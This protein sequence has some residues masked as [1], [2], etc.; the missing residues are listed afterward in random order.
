MDLEKLEETLCNLGINNFIVDY[1]EN[2]FSLDALFGLLKREHNTLGLCPYGVA[3][4]SILPYKITIELYKGDI[5]DKDTLCYIPSDLAEKLRQKY[6]EKVFNKL[7]HLMSN[8]QYEGVIEF[9]NKLISDRKKTIMA[10]K[11]LDVD[12]LS[13]EGN[14]IASEY[15]KTLNNG[16]TCRLVYGHTK[17]HKENTKA[18]LFEKDGYQLGYIAIEQNRYGDV[19]LRASSCCIENIIKYNKDT[20]KKNILDLIDNFI[21]S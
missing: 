18:I 3:T 9:I 4:L 2:L 17:V 12:K 15:L 1:N 21:L 7:Y 10:N 16:V 19:E 5:N 6:G 20:F 8:K 13:K 14:S 11:N